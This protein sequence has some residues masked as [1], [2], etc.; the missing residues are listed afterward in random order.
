MRQTSKA[1]R[2]EQYIH[3]ALKMYEGLE[4]WYDEH[5]EA[6]FAEIEQ[7]ARASRRELMGQAM[8]I[9]I[10]G[11]STGAQV[12]APRCKECGQAMVL[13]EYRE[14]TIQG[15]EGDTRLERAYYVCPDGCGQTLF[16][17]GPTIEAAEGAVE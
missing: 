6:T 11:R 4:E 16:P 9:V 12:E 1:R 5:P 17:P 15:L 14:K 7:Q 8:E 13:H 10:N 2:R 3:C